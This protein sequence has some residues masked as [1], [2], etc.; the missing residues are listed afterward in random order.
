[1]LKSFPYRNA[2][3]KNLEEMLSQSPIACI[4]IQALYFK[5]LVFFDVVFQCS[6]EVIK[7][8]IPSVLQS[9]TCF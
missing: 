9:L 8:M 4:Q 2:I 1:M 6:Y 7:F 3:W 5:M